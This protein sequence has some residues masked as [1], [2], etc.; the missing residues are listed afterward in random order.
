MKHAL[1]H[2]LAD[3]TLLHLTSQCLWHLSQC[4]YSI[5]QPAGAAEVGTAR[6]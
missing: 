6:A 1:P 5:M 4:C 3:C 2:R